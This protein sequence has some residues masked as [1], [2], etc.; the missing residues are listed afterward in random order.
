M[1]QKGGVSLP[2]FSKTHKYL[3]D[4]GIEFNINLYLVH[5][6]TLRKVHLW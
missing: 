3:T 4:L 1:I 6:S 2:Y 5:S